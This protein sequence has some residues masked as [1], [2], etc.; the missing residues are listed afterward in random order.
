MCE[1]D[2]V[3]V[4]AWVQAIGSI[5]AIGVAIWIGERSSLRSRDLVEQERR[6]QADIFASSFSTRIGLQAQEAEHKAKH[7]TRLAGRPPGSPELDE[8][9]L[10]GLFLLP[11]ANELLEQRRDCLLF[12]RDSGIAVMI[13]LD[14]LSSYNPTTD[15]MI[16]MYS[17]RAGG[18]RDLPSLCT[19]IQSRLIFV[20]EA[21]R[22]AE[23]RLEV[24]HELADAG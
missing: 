5:A 21:L 20:A 9:M 3:A 12:D 23:Q 19:E 11:N 4:A 24:A 18:Q 14:A 10:K 2:W 6:R 15:T 16:V 13:A 7:A 8:Q 17:F 22:Q 1:V